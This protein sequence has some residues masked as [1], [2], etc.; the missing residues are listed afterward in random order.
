MDRAEA[1][2]LDP[3]FRC[4][5]LVARLHGVIADPAALAHELAPPDRPAGTAEVLQALKSLG[6]RARWLTADPVA[7]GRLPLPA[8]GLSREGR[9]FVL[10]Q[11]DGDRVLVQDPAAAGP[12]VVNA[13]TLAAR[14]DGRVVLVTRRA[15]LSGEPLR[16]GLRWFVPTLLKYRGLLGEVLAA[17][18]FLQLL[19]LATPLFFQVVVDKV[20]AHRGLTTLDVLAVG[21]LAASVFEALLG[22]LRTYLFAH[23]TS[24]IDAEL[25][26]RVFRHL[27]ALPMAYFD[28]RRVG[29]SVAR[30][31]E[32]EP[33]RAF[34]TGSSLTL[35]LDLL[36]TGVFLALMWTYSVTLTGVVLASLPVYA[37]LSA[38]LT[39]AL[40]ARVEERFS[41]GAENQAFLVE[42]VA[43]M[44]TLKAMAVEPH[45]RRR[46]ED[47]LA[48]YV[49]ASFRAG[50][51][52][53]VA[54]QAAGLVG[55][56]V[57][58]ATLWLGARL[59]LGGALSVGELV[60]FNMLAGRVTGPVLRLVQLWQDVQQVRVSV[61][62]LG[63]VL[64]AP[65]ESSAGVT[66]SRPRIAGRVQFEHV[67]FRYRPDGPLVL[68]D[69]SL[70]VAPGE[71]VGVVG[72]SGSGKS[73]LA[74]LVQRLHVPERGR[75]LV[76][77]VDLAQVDPVWLRR[78]VGVVLQENVLFNRSV[79]ENIALADPGMP[80]E[81]VVHAA[82]LAGAHE[83]ILALPRGYD[84]VVAEQGR[85][86]SGGQRQRIA[87]AR[88][89]ATDPRIL[90]FDEATSALDY[91]SERVIQA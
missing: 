23:T 16:F 82:R 74:R 22:G 73:T 80:L 7:P 21:L 60:A 38:G 33:V 61:E 32:L 67:G 31:R 25:G 48:A 64:N 63:D 24:R 8:I 77:A 81:R 2:G 1:G 28:A 88:A 43:G 91:E 12:E 53:N 6:L 46:W 17:S 57:T 3:A 49:R 34:L 9:W 89:L 18:F 65:A 68:E 87:I 39:P 76:D 71:V 37:L 20:L 27:L 47:Q 84:T 15:G 83:F 44:E 86:L 79:R 19:A 59:V 41:R 90:I 4:V 85:S 36:F 62:R 51:L 13:A 35:V 5:A 54:G 40:R 72:P 50:Q 69:V 66:G 78:Q 14:W 75:V 10:A 11:S 56:V 70:E 30:V 29:D 42:A 52:G 45:F 58:V 26:A 55:K